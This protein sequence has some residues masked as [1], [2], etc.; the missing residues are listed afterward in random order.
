[1]EATLDATLEEAFDQFLVSRIASGVKDIT[2]QTYRGHFRSISKHIDTT[3]KITS[4]EKKDVD[5]VFVSM[6][7]QNLSATT[8]QT[9]SR[10]LVT[11]F[12]WANAEGISTLKLKL[13]KAD[14]TM[15]EPYS[16]AELQQL[17]ADPHDQCDFWELRDW[18]IVNFLISSGCRAA[19]LLA[20]LIGDID[21]QNN[22]VYFRHTKNGHAQTMPLCARM[23]SILELYLR[24]RHGSKNNPLFCNDHFAPLTYPTLRKS[25]IKYNHSRGVMKTSIHLFRHTFAKKFILDC[26]GN[27]FTLQHLLGHKS[28]E[29]TRRY[30]DLYDSDIANHFEAICPLNK[31]FN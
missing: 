24:R 21:L 7:K 18:V 15:K 2:I 28:L 12:N 20:I 13:Y 6:R 10:C 1:M 9:Y 4:V 17:L 19:T 14:K 29:M 25:L 31:I 3:Q 5:K 26:G 22:I 11:F 23:S 27:A 8:I 16:D 30:C